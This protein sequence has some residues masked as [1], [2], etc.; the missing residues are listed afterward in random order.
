MFE[1]SRI[2]D[3]NIS[4]NIQLPSFPTK[5]QDQ[6][7]FNR[8]YHAVPRIILKKKKAK[9]L[10]QKLYYRIINSKFLT[11]NIILVIYTNIITISNLNFLYLSSSYLSLRSRKQAIPFFSFKESVIE[12]KRHIYIYIYI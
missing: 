8:I 9:K 2:Y 12:E 3:E 11:L 10:L 5:V 6:F 1:N 4:S 7:F